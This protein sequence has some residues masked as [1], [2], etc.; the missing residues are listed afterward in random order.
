MAKIENLGEGN[1]GL[2][3]VHSDG[4]G[5]IC[6]FKTKEKRDDMYNYRIKSRKRR[7][8]VGVLSHTIEKIDK[9]S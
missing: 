3:V 9:K 8:S 6:W 2:K 1:Y 5:S 7:M 4:S